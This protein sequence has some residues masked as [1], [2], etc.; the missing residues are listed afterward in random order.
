MLI[1]PRHNFFIMVMN[2]FEDEETAFRGLKNL[3]HNYRAKD[4]LK[5]KLSLPPVS[6]THLL[7]PFTKGYLLA[8]LCHLLYSYS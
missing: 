5:M 4:L 8:S 1:F 3:A 2:F 7:K 6:R